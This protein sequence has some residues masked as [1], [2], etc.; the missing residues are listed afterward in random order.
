MASSSESCK[1]E[2]PQKL[3]V[4]ELFAGI[5]GWRL[6]L[7]SA[8][9]GRSP[10]F[11]ARYEAYDSGPH[12]SEIYAWNFGEACSRR[13]I[14]QL[15]I[16]DTDGF[17]VWVMSP[18]CQP[19]S[20]TRE[21][22]QLDIEDKRCK[23]L[24]HLTK[25]IVQLE[26]PPSYI[27]LE[28]VKG[29]YTSEACE[30][31][32]CALTKIGYTFK[33]YLL[34]LAS[35]GVP[36]HRTRYYLLAER[37]SRFASS[38]EGSDGIGD[39]CAKRRKVDEEGA[40]SDF[41]AAGF[42]P[43]LLARGPW[44]ATLRPVVEKAHQDAHQ[45]SDADT[46]SAIFAQL[47]S[48]LASELRKVLEDRA[49]L[50]PEAPLFAGH[51]DWVV[52]PRPTDGSAAKECVLIS[53]PYGSSR[54]AARELLPDLQQTFAADADKGR[55]H[56]ASWSWVGDA[57]SGTRPISEF[58]ESSF[59]PEE[60]NELLLTEAILK[61]PFARG[62]SYVK[63]GDAQS[64]CFTGHYGKVIHKSSGSLFHFSVSEEPLDRDNLASA[65]G[66]IR[67]FSPKEVLNFL[68]FP[69]SYSIPQGI[70]LKHCYKSVGNSIAVCVCS[71]L[72]RMLLFGEGEEDLEAKKQKPPERGVEETE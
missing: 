44:A 64:F 38:S 25:L 18:P 50:D 34:D 66:T 11:T 30:Q 36:N 19:F 17:D 47:R 13:N 59:S 12:C 5:G 40:A 37:S 41:E 67:F 70:G 21:A 14:E 39:V 29:F 55:D 62:L 4:L 7:E 1:P 9:E 22:K 63:G 31:F 42:P 26:S 35:F 49:G 23:A 52:L 65:A 48:H 58:L 46:K 8:L 54:K 33:E 28:N 43:G 71:Q 53:F 3:R 15:Q 24:E 68:G 57:V 61:K 51:A 60:L 72:L 6:S 69:R 45:A 16:K 32:R 10:A 2:L 27:A 20:K 56:L